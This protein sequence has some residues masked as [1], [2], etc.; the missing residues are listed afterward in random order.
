MSTLKWIG[1][2]V[3]VAG[4]YVAY[5]KRDKIQKF[6]IRKFNEMNENWK[7]AQKEVDEELEKRVREK[8]GLRINPH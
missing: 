1:L 5:K 6:A 2:G 4:G 7:Q 8:K 3:L